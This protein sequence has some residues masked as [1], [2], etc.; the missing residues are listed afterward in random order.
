VTTPSELPDRE[1]RVGIAGGG[2]MGDVHTHAAR[3]AG[4]RVA[5][6]LASSPER[7]AAAAARLGV[8]RAYGSFDELVAD[9]DV[10]HVCT[11]NALHAPQAM[12]ALAAG[13]HV[14]CE[15]PLA[16]SVGEAEELVAAVGDRVASVPFVYRFHPM[17]REARARFRDGTAGVPVTIAGSYLQDWLLSAD[18]DNWRVDDAEGGPSRAFADIGSH[19]VDLV[20]FVTG[21]RIARLVATTRTLHPTRGGRSVRSEDAAAL[22]VVTAGGAIGTLLVSQVAPGRKN[23]LAVE[24]AGTSESVAFDQEQPETLWIGRRAGSVLLPRDAAQL[25]PDAARLSRLPAGHPQGYQD[26]FDAFV[27]DTYAAVTGRTP[28]GLP[29]FADGLRAARITEAVLASAASG[30]WVETGESS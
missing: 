19:L 26:A 16:T 22:T 21:D 3:V 14:V 25:T 11:P 6:V 1:L 28:D 4:A 15:K 23:R 18:D 5:G 27:A 29:T 10:V 30:A 13:R 9:V 17:V 20:E 24:I 8:P 12:A 2:F 7:S